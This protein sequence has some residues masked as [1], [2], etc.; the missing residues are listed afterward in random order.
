MKTRILAAAAVVLAAAT[1]ARADIPSYYEHLDF[2]LTSPTGFTHAAG[3]FINPSVYPMMPGG[4]IE[5]FWT[6]YE[7][8]YSDR[9]GLFTGI[10]NLGFGAVHN[11]MPGSDVSVTDY[12]LGLAGG[13]RMATFGLSYGWSGGDED[14]FAR[15]SIMQAGLTWRF[16]RYLSLGAVEEWGLQ[17]GNRR[18]VVDLGVRPLG[19]DRLTLFGDFETD[20]VDGDYSD[21]VP[22]SAGAMVEVPAGLKLIGRFHDAKDVDGTFSLAIAYSFGGGFHQGVMRGSFQERFE[23]DSAPAVETYGIR[24]GYPERSELL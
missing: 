9:W 13:T 10:E 12:R 22:W 18:E 20:V 15:E 17:T 5:F 4:E 2:N 16:N 14:A 3:G 24:L 23:S 8:I 6:D 21:N 11:R 19:N 1:G 7:E